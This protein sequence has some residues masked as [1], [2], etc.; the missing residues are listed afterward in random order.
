M[1]RALMIAG[2][3]FAVAAGAQLLRRAQ[4]RG[5]AIRIDASYKRLNREPHWSPLTD[6]SVVPAEVLARLDEWEALCRRE[7]QMTPLARLKEH[8]ADGELIGVRS[9]LLNGERTIAATF[10][11]SH[12]NPKVSFRS[13]GSFADDR[14][15]LT[16]DIKSRFQRP[17]NIVYQYVDAAMPAG[18]MYR[19]QIAHLKNRSA[20]PR[21]FNGVNSYIDM[22]TRMW[23]QTNALRQQ[24]G[25]V[26]DA[27]SL[28]RL[29]P[30]Q[31]SDATLR[32]I[33]SEIV[34][35]NRK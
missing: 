7:L 8:Y 20:T 19:A 2:V 24:A 16:S 9:V 21:P 11:V 5:K 15:L 1:D 28:R 6:P 25:Y 13:F 33:H 31:M 29:A 10:A 14:F 4:I 27:E 30:Q 23:S 12:R 32:E 3:A 22:Q 34:R 35:L 26:M 18:D 17:D